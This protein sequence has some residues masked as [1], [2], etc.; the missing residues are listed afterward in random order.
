[1]RGKQFVRYSLAAMAIERWRSPFLVSD[2]LDVPTIAIFL[3]LNGLVLLNATRHHPRV[4]YDSLEHLRYIEVMAQ[5]RLPSPQ[6]SDQFFAAPLSYALPALF[7][8]ANVGSP[9]AEARFA[10]LLNVLWSIGL[11]L[12]L[13]RI[14]RLV[15]P[16][17]AHLRR[18]ALLFLGMTATYYRTFAFV[19]GEALAVFLAAL[20]AERVLRMQWAESTTPKDWGVLGLILGLLMLAK[21]WG[22]FVVA[23]VLL[24]VMWRALA[25]TGWRRAHTLG[26]SVLLAVIV[27][28]SGWFYA[29]LYVRFGTATAFN[30]LPSDS[31]SLSN[32]SLDFYLNAGLPN[33]FADPIRPHFSPNDDTWFMPVLYS[34]TWGD[35]WCYWIAKRRDAEQ[36][37]PLIASYLG[38]VNLAGVLPTIIVLV[39]VATGFRQ[40]RSVSSA[41]GRER[42][43]LVLSTAVFATTAVGYFVLLVKY[44]LLD[45]KSSYMLHLAP[46]LAL[47]AAVAV[48]GLSRMA[49]RLGA[50]T[51]ALLLL[52]IA[53][54]APTY[55]T[56]YLS[57]S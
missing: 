17:D 5:G 50:V 16:D 19:R 31:W 24:Y 14:C 10:Q 41:G 9:G 7:A 28:V 36:M 20:A 22:A 32:R 26:I 46:F 42:D 6:E 29:S 49:P 40:W 4:G 3:L 21:Q 43:L 44:P 25:T 53:H 18:W 34:D 2:R 27:A 13:L 23:A 38:R 57:E 51:R 33:L 15:A 1:M 52:V 35:Y 45:V 48:S 55:V 12:V 37:R 8:A 47:L 54:N 56:R 39:G 11:T 30:E